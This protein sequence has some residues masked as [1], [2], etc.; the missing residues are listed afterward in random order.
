M[1]APRLSS[2][3]KAEIIIK[4]AAWVESIGSERVCAETVGMTDLEASIG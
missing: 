4:E 2:N 1:H 3:G